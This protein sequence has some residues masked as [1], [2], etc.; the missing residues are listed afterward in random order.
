[1]PVVVNSYRLTE[2]ITPCSFSGT[3][4]AGGAPTTVTSSTRT[5]TVPSGNSGQVKF[6]SFDMT[7]LVTIK[8]SKNGG[9]MTTLAEDSTITFADTDTLAL[10]I[11][12]ASSGESLSLDLV[13]VTTGALIQSVS[14]VSV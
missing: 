2:S 3:L 9:A 12:S 14:L 13:D 8:Y 6:Q 5:I 10:E 4:S 1:M 7:G 11:S